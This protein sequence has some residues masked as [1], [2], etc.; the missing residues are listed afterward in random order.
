MDIGVRYRYPPDIGEG[1]AEPIGISFSLEN[2]SFKGSR[3]DKA[4]SIQ[5]LQK[6]LALQLQLELE[7]KLEH[8]QRLELARQ[9]KPK[10]QPRITPLVEN[11]FWPKR[12]HGMRHR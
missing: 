4:Y 5:A 3:I 6:T 10:V 8:Q 11:E 7:R 9:L 1:A 12:S 2:E